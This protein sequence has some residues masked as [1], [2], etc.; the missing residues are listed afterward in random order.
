MG[1]SYCKNPAATDWCFAPFQVLPDPF[2]DGSSMPTFWFAA[3]EENDYTLCCEIRIM[4]RIGVMHGVTICI[5][6]FETGRKGW[7]DARSRGRE[8]GDVGT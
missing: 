1:Q 5:F 4:W 2:M 8:P 6:V 3:R 7:D